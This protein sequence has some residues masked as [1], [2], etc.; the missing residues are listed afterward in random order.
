M[1]QILLLEPDKILAKTYSMALESA[2]HVVRHC[3]SAQ[4]AIVLADDIHPDIVIVEL[5]L[6][7]HS[8]IEFLYEFRSYTDW[9]HIPVIIL[10]NVPETEF[11]G[12]LS[13]LRNDLNVQAYLYKPL[14][15]LQKLIQCVEDLTQVTIKK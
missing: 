13:L 7:D 9:Q 4:T 2:G 11:S 6:V 10:T 12:S 5:Q 3:V 1:S 14:T 15:N 8:G